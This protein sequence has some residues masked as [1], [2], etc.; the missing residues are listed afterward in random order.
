MLRHAA[1]RIALAVPVMFGVLLV[2]FLLMQVVPT[3]PAVGPRRP[4]RKR[5]GDRGDPPRPWPGPAPAGAVRALRLAAAQGDL[6]VSIINNVPVSQ[7]LRAT[8]G[9]TLS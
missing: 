5:R 4:D 2:G 7:E 6:G 9:P 8:I 1:Q 3:D